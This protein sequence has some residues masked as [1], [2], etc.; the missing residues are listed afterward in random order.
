MIPACC[1]SKYKQSAATTGDATRWPLIFELHST[2]SL[3]MLSPVSEISP[4]A[5]DL[6]AATMPRWP[7]SRSAEPTKSK[8]PDATGDGEQRPLAAISHSNLP[9][10]GS[11]DRIFV[12]PAATSSV[13]CEF[14]QMIGVA[15]FEP[16]SRS[17]RQTSSPVFL[18]SATRNDV[19]SLSHWIN[20]SSRCI[21]G[22]LPVPQS[23]CVG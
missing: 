19:L 5:P 16:S 14:F 17:V 20:T 10:A 11:Y 13:R 6:I 9:L 21:T 22:E 1:S 12:P 18:S 15:Q 23:I 4:L 2:K 3:V 8:S 7:V